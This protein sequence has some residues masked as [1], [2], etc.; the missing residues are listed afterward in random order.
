MPR[1]GRRI[2]LTEHGH[3]L[4][5]CQFSKAMNEVQ[6]ETTIMEAFG[7]TIPALVDIEIVMSVH[8]NL[9][10][11]MLA[12]GQQGITGVILHRLFRNKPVVCKA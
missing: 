11:P 12:P 9:V 5:A 4:S 1:Q 8:N 3:V 10:K 7:E 2:A 6:V